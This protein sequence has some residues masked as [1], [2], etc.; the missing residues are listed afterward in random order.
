VIRAAAWILGL[1]LVAIIATGIF[2]SRAAPA[3][4]EAYWAAVTPIRPVRGMPLEHWR[5]QVLYDELQ[6]VKLTNCVLERFGEAN[7]GG[8]VVCAN[9]LKDVRAGY[10]YG[11]SGYD[12]WGCDI[13]TRLSIPMHQYDC[14]DLRQPVCVSGKTIFH[15]ECVGG[16]SEI[17]ENRPYDSIANQLRKNGDYPHH[18]VLKMDVEGSEWDSFMNIPEELLDRIDQLAIEMH[19]VSDDKA[20]TI[21]RHLKRHFYIVSLHYNNFACY[22]ASDPFPAY[23]FEVLFVNRR[24]G[25]LDPAGKAEHPSPLNH[26]NNPLGP[27]CQVLT[28]K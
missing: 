1:V 14:F 18:V 27:D 11:I 16:R 10:S 3:R 22:P 28:K 9:L 17:I 12:K 6:P 2:V 19:G 20:R 24:I 21:V 23:V 8:Y 5:R 13:S 4:S 7:D 15:A 26:P 25:V